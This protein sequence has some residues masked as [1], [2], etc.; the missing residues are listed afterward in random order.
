MRVKAFSISQYPSAIQ[1]TVNEQ[2]EILE[3]KGYIVTNIKFYQGKAIIFY[4]E[5][6]LNFPINYCGQAQTTTAPA[7]NPTYTMTLS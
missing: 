2:I 3:S 6:T 1:D 5:K 4:D 7:L